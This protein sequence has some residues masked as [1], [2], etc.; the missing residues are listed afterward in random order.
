MTTQAAIRVPLALRSNLTERAFFIGMALSMLVTVFAGFAP[1]YFLRRPDAEP[2]TPLLHIHGA[3]STAWMLLFL[4]Q[5]GLVAAH[6]VDIHR[7]LGL[8]GGAV[9]VALTI[10]TAAASIVSRGFTAR[11]TFSAGAV[12]MFAIYV[13]AG[14]LKRREPD[15]H[16]RWMLLA[17]ITLLPPAI[18]RMDVP[19][20]PHN[21]FGPNFVGLFF[22][23]PAFA[24]DLATRSRIHPALLWG[25]LFMIVMLP[26]RLFLKAYVF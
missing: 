15:A 21:S 20:M 8:T 11:V 19:Y 25:G 5:A 2:L 14:F 26:L 13:V 22:L 10:F 3:L 7:R 9:A 18:S 23:I 4:T 24:Y 12:L 1:S 16:K 6:R 17:T